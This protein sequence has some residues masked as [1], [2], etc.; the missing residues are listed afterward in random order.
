MA[1]QR[2]AFV[3]NDAGVRL[4]NIA[5]GL[6]PKFSLTG[7]ELDEACEALNRTSSLRGGRIYAGG[8]AKFEPR[9]VEDILIDWAPRRR[10]E[11]LPLAAVMG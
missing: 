10:Q 5:H 9:A 11:D 2:P 3:R 6:Y 7:D 4:L 8:L 1:R